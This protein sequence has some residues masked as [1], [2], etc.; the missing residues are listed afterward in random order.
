MTPRLLVVDDDPD[1]LGFLERYLTGQGFG[2]TTAAD[3]DAALVLIE[4]KKFDLVLLDLMMPGRDGLDVARHIR[5]IARTPIIMVT[6]RSD[7]VDRIIGLELGA[8][9]YLGKPFN[10]RELA[11]RIRSVLRRSGAPPEEA[12]ATTTPGATLAFAG[13]RLD[14]ARRQLLSP[15]DAEV[16]LTVG[17]YN[18]LLAFANHPQQVLSR[19]KLLDCIHDYDTYSFDRSVD[20][21]ILRL[22]RKIETNPQQPEMIRTVRGAGYLFV[23]KVE[24]I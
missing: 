22:R 3:G 16:E 9:D 10:P 11:A 15:T 6:A 12:D 24:R 5:T 7:E 23:P 13:W 21:R 1:V 19:E 14:T 8:D 17:E 20:V 18:L 2:V 4:G